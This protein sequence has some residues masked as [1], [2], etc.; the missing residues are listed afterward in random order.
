MRKVRIVSSEQYREEYPIPAGFEPMIHDGDQIQTG[1]ILA[2]LPGATE[3]Y[4]QEAQALTQVS[5][6]CGGRKQ[7]RCS[8]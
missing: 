7:Q 6:G 4:R 2:A 1:Q 3:A 5:E 8:R